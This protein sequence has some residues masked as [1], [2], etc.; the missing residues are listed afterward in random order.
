MGI[1]N[2]VR[3]RFRL[4]FFK[5][6]IY[7]L[8]HHQFLP[9]W[10]QCSKKSSISHTIGVFH[11]N[12]CRNTRKTDKVYDFLPI[13][14]SCLDDLWTQALRPISQSLLA[15]SIWNH[16]L[17]SFGI[18]LHRRDFPFSEFKGHP[19][20]STLRIGGKKREKKKRKSKS[21]TNLVWSTPLEIPDRE[22]GGIERK[23]H[24]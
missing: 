22:K 8:I 19:R 7:L 14:Q 3:H 18:L 21:V 15:A 5:R 13:R 4:S 17:T 23:C 20:R 24:L 1:S 12:C 10:Y 16:S 6:T 2:K 11:H 9:F